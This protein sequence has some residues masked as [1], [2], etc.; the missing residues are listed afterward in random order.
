MDSGYEQVLEGHVGAVFCMAQGGAYLFSGGDDFGVKTWQF[1][2]AENNFKPLIELK[3]HQSPVQTMKTTSAHLITAD[4]SGIVAKWDLEKGSLLGTITTG[5]QNA[6]MALW[7]EESFLFTA[8]LDGHVKVWDND[9]QQQFD[10][11][12]ANLH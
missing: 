6:L 9:G 1:D 4:R 10:H 2:A 8:S 5:H 7:V 12:R 3:G 11:V